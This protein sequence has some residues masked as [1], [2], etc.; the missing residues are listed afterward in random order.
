MMTAE[1]G[2]V[3][4]PEFPGAGQDRMRVAVWAPDILTLNGL[5]QALKGH[6]DVF[7]A[8]N[9][10]PDDVHVLVVAADWIDG[11]AIAT[12]RR[13][14][15]RTAAPVVLV[16]SGLDRSQLLSAVE[17]RVVSVLHRSLVTEES[18]AGAIRLAAEGR[19]ALPPDLLGNLLRQV[20]NLQQEA[21]TPLGRN[22]AGMTQREIDVVRMLAEG[23]DSEEIGNRL[24]YSERTVKNI[25]YMLTRRLKVRNRPHLVAYAMRAGII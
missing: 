21:L 4:Y 20:Q 15:G 18:L 1:I 16:T 10:L 25:I 2:S 12:L 23:R 22:T 24:C 13:V 11:E 8:T 19:G 14:A 9:E 7:P 5:V 17:C 6:L 3:T